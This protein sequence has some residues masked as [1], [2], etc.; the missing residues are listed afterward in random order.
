MW[1]IA[2]GAKMARVQDKYTGIK[3]NFDDMI[4]YYEKFN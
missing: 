1:F 4:E 2:N 3:E